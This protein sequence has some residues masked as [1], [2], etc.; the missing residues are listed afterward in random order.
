[1]QLCK[2][3]N[4]QICKYANMQLCK[5]ANMQLCKYAN[6]QIT[7]KLLKLLPPLNLRNSGYRATPELRIGRLDG[8]F[9]VLSF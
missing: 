6:M 1:M 5:Y 8:K 3:T 7:L 4:M 9:R 2:Y